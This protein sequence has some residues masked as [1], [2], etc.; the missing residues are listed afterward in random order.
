MNKKTFLNQALPAAVAALGFAL[1]SAAATNDESPNGQEVQ[2][3][4][5]KVIVVKQGTRLGDRT[6]SY[7]LSNQVK[8]GDLDL[9]TRAGKAELENRIRDTANSVC[10]QLMDIGPPTSAM[11]RFEDRNICV[12]DATAG[13]MTRARLLISMAKQAKQVG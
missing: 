1:S 7:Q 12:H 13:A 6:E 2:I 3:Q 9:T 11:S 5:G 10:D 8:V 4:A